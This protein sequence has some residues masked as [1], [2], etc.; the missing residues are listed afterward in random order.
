MV[1]LNATT[2][3]ELF[4]EL[5]LNGVYTFAGDVFY[6]LIVFLSAIIG[7]GRGVIGAVLSAL[8]VHT[9]I[10]VMVMVGY[11]PFGGLYST[12]GGFLYLA[13]ALTLALIVKRA[14]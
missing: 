6:F 11:L 7:F 2:I 10:Y 12:I 5:V 9:L 3:S 14:V 1:W 4:Y 8:F 13:L